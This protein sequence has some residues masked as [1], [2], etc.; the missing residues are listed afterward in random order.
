MNTNDLPGTTGEI[1]ALH[2]IA[3]LPL[4]AGFPLFRHYPAMKY[5]VRDSVRFFAR[6]LQP[7]AEAILAGPPGR[8]N[9]VVTAPPLY[10]I[11]S[12]ANLIAWELCRIL[13]G[14]RMI[15]VRYTAPHPQGVHDHYSNTGVADRIA[16]RRMLHEG[17]F[18]PKPAE[19]DF[20]GRAVLVINDIHVTGVQ[21]EFL[22]RTLETACPSRICWLYIIRLAP[23]LGRTNPRIEYQLNH[24]NLAAFEEFADIVT[25]AEIDYTSRSVARMLASSDAELEALLRALDGERRARLHRLMT[26][27]GAYAAEQHRLDRFLG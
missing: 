11:P 10:V 14:A 4:D 7:R 16:D 27:E 25:R 3:G 6:E 26:E 13:G 12:G 2:T 21:Q 23:P 15:D 22:R 18:A 17:E 20:R 9:W 8:E 24:L 19:A 5:G 1:V